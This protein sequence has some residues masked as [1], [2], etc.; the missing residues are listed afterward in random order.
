MK[1]LDYITSRAKEKD[2]HAVL[3]ATLYS[4]LKLFVPAQ[5]QTLLDS[6][7]GALGTAIVVTPNNG[8]KTQYT[9]T[10]KTTTEIPE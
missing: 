1:L 2:T 8:N 9:S 7:A 5:Y 4:V 10:I 3:I 6:I